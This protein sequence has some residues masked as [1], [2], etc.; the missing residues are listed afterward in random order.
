[1]SDDV[2]PPESSSTTGLITQGATAFS[3]GRLAD[4]RVL[5]ARAL[6]ANP[7]SEA[8]WLW[9]AT[10]AEDPGEQ[11]YALNRAL[12]INPESLGL[13]RLVVLPPG[14]ATIPPDLIELDEPPLPPDLAA[15]SRVRLVAVPR[16]AVVRQHRRQA[17]RSS[18][19]HQVPAAEAAPVPALKPMLRWVLV[20]LVLAAVVV[21]AIAFF[22]QQQQGPAANAYVIA[23]AGPLTG[24]DAA[25]GQEQLRAVELTAETLNEAGGIG[26]RP[27]E[28]VSYDDANDPARAAEVAREIVANDRV[29]LVI[30][31]ANSGAALATAPIYEDAGLA[32]ITPS[33][34]ADALT[35]NDP[36]YFRSIFTNHEEGEL[37]AA[38]SRDVLKNERASIIST[39]GE[40]ESSL[41][42]AFADRF[43]QEGTVVEQ[44]RIDPANLEASAASVVEALQ[45]AD[46][47]GIVFLALQP[48]EAQALL[49]ARGRAGVTV[50]VIGGEAIGYVE[51]A[52]LFK[53]EPEEIEQPGFFTN[54][55]YVA[56]PMIYDS[57]GGDALAF[58]EHFRSVYGTAPRWF[59]AKANDAVTLAAH[60]I[61]DL[62]GLTNPSADIAARRLATRDA[63]A[64]IDSV[65][66]AIPGLSGPLY[67]DA[68]RST[69]PTLSFGLFD[70]R[71]LLSAPLQYRAVDEGSTVDLAADKAAGLTFEID[72]QTYRQ[73]RVAYV[74][75]DINEISNLNMQAQT[76]DADFFLWFR[77]LGDPSAENV[78]FSNAANPAMSLP[79][80]LGRSEE[81]G[82][83]FAIFRIDTTFVE[84]MNFQDYP[85][86]THVLT[87]NLENLNLPQTDIVYV[88]DQSNIRQPQA[89]RLRSGIDF[90]RPFN[91][92][93]GWI[94]EHVFFAQESTIT[95]ATTLNPSTG[96]PE[97]QQ[98]S[99]YQVQ[100][101]YARDVRS[102]LIK[103]L[104]PLALVALVT[105]IS[106]FF[107]PANA[108]T[109]IGFSIT[110]I[111][112][113]SVLLQ[114]V[115][116][117]LPDVGY[118]VA[119]EWVYYVYIG[120]SALL[121]LLNI[122]IERWYKA[123]RFAAVRQLDWFARILY[124]SVLLV[125]MAAYAVHFG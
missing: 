54:G 117:N 121:V 86:D 116:G 94:A 16:P 84:P 17:A 70:F 24:A 35:A 83:Q 10:V 39:T 85:W 96:A 97:Y 90:T 53:D 102:F 122:T 58:A 57:L 69:P 125:V 11:R 119:I 74:G 66:N 12:A 124:P 64:A 27:L 14:P 21:A 1:M 33:A 78:F 72:G 29:V 9:F 106:L 101:S 51:F 32:A 115:S 6:L 42:S 18:R 60:A 98:A 22:R 8:G 120:L 110:A 105:Y 75:V 73:Y 76:F 7:E 20:A 23:F 88:P 107:S 114:S 25:V 67:F 61:T 79:E 82:E 81:L 50:P 91:R 109:R 99:T 89:E 108:S 43:G 30:G 55:L 65:G 38:Y 87:I 104:L 62:P 4:A 63:L 80:A 41:A 56:S 3:E 49:L 71:S 92:I 37:I 45:A 111:L 2:L 40:Y 95:R 13:H 59:A 77:Y 19:A 123:K 5:F 93:P 34:T 36:W 15:A 47:P 28:I 103:N 118:T 113:T 112:T 48:R 46:N 100:I 52:N 44:W 26:G 31:H 68:M